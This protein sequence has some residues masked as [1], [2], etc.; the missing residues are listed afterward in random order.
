MHFLLWQLHVWWLVLLGLVAWTL[1]Y[2]LLTKVV[3][4]DG[5]GD[6][7]NLVTGALP[8]LSLIVAVAICYVSF[9]RTPTHDA[10]GLFF[11]V[12]GIVALIVSIIQI[13]NSEVRN[14]MLTT[15][16]KRWKVVEEICWGCVGAVVLFACEFGMIFG[17]WQLIQGSSVVGF[18]SAGIASALAIVGHFVKSARNPIYKAIKALEVK[19]HHQ[20]RFFDRLVKNL[21]DRDK[22]KGQP[23]LHS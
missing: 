11:V 1:A 8:I 18:T 10:V 14:A 12:V 16:I 13:R 15:R 9:T 4:P 17:G 21:G 3:T 5:I 6:L 2:V 20:V 23:L 7:V 19:E 22:E